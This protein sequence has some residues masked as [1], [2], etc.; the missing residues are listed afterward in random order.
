MAD[1]QP[2]T[3][4]S[5]AVATVTR[6]V[7]RPRRAFVALGI[8]VVAYGGLHA[9]NGWQLAGSSGPVGTSADLAQRLLVVPG[10]GLPL[11]GE[12]AI[13]AVMLALLI[14]CLILL[15]S[16]L[17]AS[18]GAVVASAPRPL[19]T[20]GPRSPNS[21]GGGSTNVPT[22]TPAP[23]SSPAPAPASPVTSSTL[24]Q[25]SALPSSHREGA[26]ERIGQA[27]TPA[28]S[29]G[30]GP[31]VWTPRV[32]IS[33]SS[34]DNDFGL[35]LV[36]R[37]QEELGASGDAWYDKSGQPENDYE[38]GL[39]GGD[40]WWARIVREITERNVFVVL[41]S[42]EAMAS[43]WVRDELAFA[44]EEG[45]AEQDEGIVRIQATVR[46]VG[47]TGAEMEAL[48]AVSTAALTIY[49]MCKAVDR[50]MTLDEIGL[51]RK[52]GGKS[53]TYE[54]GEVER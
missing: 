20:P 27:R 37:I 21:A 10:T 5:P 34:A 47:K 18:P 16:A 15:P 23:A 49:D 40:S 17:R 31:G 6:R 52:S 3:P 42:P 28:S 33:H 53:G 46:T 54:R 45:A 30:E 8:F 29:Q 13:A 25:P 14:V 26:R 24:S 19:G 12:V 9:Y 32:F 11:A 43:H 1:D 41:L 4:R 35:E 51:V 22:P 39:L 38:S 36:R 48:T 44:L 7:R 50:A 2:T